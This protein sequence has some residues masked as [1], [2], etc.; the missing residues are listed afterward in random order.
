M[1]TNKKTLTARGVFW[2][3]AMRS[4]GIMLGSMAAA[5]FIQSNTPLPDQ[6]GIFLPLA[7]LAPL[8]LQ[9]IQKKLKLYLSLVN[10]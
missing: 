1:T 9:K 7:G 4:A 3:T 8:L 2:E 5:A 10:F 6:Y